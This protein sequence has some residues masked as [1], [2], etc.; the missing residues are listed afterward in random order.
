MTVSLVVIMFELTGSLSFIVPTMVAVIFAK[1]IGDAIYGMGVY[2]AHIQLNNYPFLDN[3]S[4]Y[5]FSTVAMQ[6]MQP[7]A[8]ISQ[9]K[10]I[11]QDQMVVGETED[12][13]RESSCNG[14]PV[15]VS[16]SDMFVVGY[17]ARRDLQVALTDARKSYQYVTTNSK[18]GVKI[19]SQKGL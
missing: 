2:D 17:V 10:V 8:D 6:V 5:P 7:G 14:F 15:V 4:E 9:L 11:Y 19:P 12:L 16:G 3:K 18:V 1:L 13:I